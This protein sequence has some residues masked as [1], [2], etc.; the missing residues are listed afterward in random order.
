MIVEDWT[1]CPSCLFPAAHSS[2]RQFVSTEKLCPMCEQTVSL[3]QVVR[4]DNPVPLLKK[5]LADASGVDK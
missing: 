5:L 3:A 4:E 1:Q 2:F